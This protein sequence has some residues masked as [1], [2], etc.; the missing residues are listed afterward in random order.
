LRKKYCFDD[1]EFQNTVNTSNI[2]ARLSYMASAGNTHSIITAVLGEYCDSVMCD[3]LTNQWTNCSLLN[4]ADTQLHVGISYNNKSWGRFQHLV[5]TEHNKRTVTTI[6][7]F[8]RMIIFPI[9]QNPST[10]TKLWRKMLGHII[11]KTS[12]MVSS[13]YKTTVQNIA[14]NTIYLKG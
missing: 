11:W 2:L 10:R 3:K 14:M 13:I 8:S 4:I 9:I 7:M 12:K 1:R 6:H 5:K